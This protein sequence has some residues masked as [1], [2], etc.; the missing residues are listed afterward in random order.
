[1]PTPRRSRHVRCRWCGIILGG[2]LPIPNRPESSM[3]LYHL[4]ADHLAEARP[5]LQRMNTT[6]DIDVVVM[7]IF[8]RVEAPGSTGAP[9]PLTPPR[10]PA[11]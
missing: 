10:P 8:E 3:L 1:M 6:E 2:W 9:P 5:Y 7:E 11:R 4:G